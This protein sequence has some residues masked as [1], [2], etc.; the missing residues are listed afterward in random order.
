MKLVLWRKLE[1]EREIG[2]AGNISGVCVSVCADA[3]LQ[4]Q[5]LGA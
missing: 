3:Q 5:W 2:S 1:Q 4:I